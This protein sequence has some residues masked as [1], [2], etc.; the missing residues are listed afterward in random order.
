M[1]SM[2]IDRDL[3]A[4]KPKLPPGYGLEGSPEGRLLL[5]LVEKDPTKRPTGLEIEEKYMNEWEE[6]L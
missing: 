6:A 4:N 5:A 3:K 1:V 2:R